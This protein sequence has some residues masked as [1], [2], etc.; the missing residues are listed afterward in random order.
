MHRLDATIVVLS[1]ED[2]RCSVVGTFGFGNELEF[3]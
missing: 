3:A 2:V 1:H